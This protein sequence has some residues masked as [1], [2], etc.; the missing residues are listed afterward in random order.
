MA[1][2]VNQPESAV[3]GVTGRAQPSRP[4]TRR[5]GGRFF[6]FLLPLALYLGA[7]AYL[8]LITHAIV[9]DAWSRAGNAYYVLFSRDP[10]LAAIGFVW[11]PLPSLLEMPLVLLHD[12]WPPLITQGYAAC[13]L[14]ALSMAGAVYLL[15]GTL[16]DWNVPWL[17]RDAITILFALHPMIVEYGADGD[18]EAVWLL[19]LLL[20][21]RSFSRWI[22]DDDTAS[23][24]ITGIG[25]ALAYMVRYEAG[26]IAIVAVGLVVPATYHRTSGTTKARLVAGV[27]DALVAGTPFAV[28]F[29]GWAIASYL[30]VGNPFEQFSSAYGTTSQLKA[31]SG[32][33]A[34]LGQGV[35]AIPWVLA[36]VGSLEPA[37][38]LLALLALMVAVIRR[39]PRVLAPLCLLGAVLAFAGFVYATGR[40]GGWMRYYITAV[41][42][43]CLLAGIL[44][45]R[46]VRLPG[47]PPAGRRWI[48]GIVRGLAA[49]ATIASIAVALPVATWAMYNTTLGTGE[50]DQ[51]NQT[52]AYRQ[53]E[54]VA[55]AIDGMNLG[56]GSVLVDVFMGFPVVLE[57]SN[58]TQF[59]IT[60]DRDFKPTVA[61]PDSFDVRY[62]LV[63]EPTGLAT[64]DAL[65]HQWPGIYQDGAG[66]GKLVREFPALPG[67]PAWRLYAVR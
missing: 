63:P 6:F 47:L 2:L 57:S 67:T 50:Q 55:S 64:L 56:R 12:L 38:F 53:G 3:G 60:P 31:D 22:R 58:P 20:T 29:V 11:N 66:I 14:S 17:A 62:L 24:A 5:P 42:L 9:G 41:P 61:A 23:L 18:S 49:L 27:A 46:P 54:L 21:I 39:D 8:N 34:H 26:A 7:G 33:A 4:R 19:L 15:R 35:S 59:V 28:A 44:L 16:R 45:A 32:L 1:R 37:L 40:T 65:N 30:I 25:I 43:A 10:H 52:A 51:A 48:P 36:Q 13:I